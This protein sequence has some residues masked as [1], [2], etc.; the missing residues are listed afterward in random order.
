MWGLSYGIIEKR[1]KKL[2]RRMVA[3]PM[4][5]SYFLIGLIT[6]RVG[7]NFVE[8]GLLL[9]FSWLVFGITIQGNIPALIALFIAGNIAF[10]GIAVFISCHTSSTEV[11]NG[12]INAVVMPMMVLSGVFFSYHNFPD[13]SISFIQKLPLTMVADGIRSLI[14]EGAGIM[15]VSASFFILVAIGVVFFGAGLR[16]FKWY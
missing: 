9:L 6:V 1:S 14:I 7:M 11:G 10:A 8:S 4:K 13:W 3:T 12:F 2:L 5:K 16:I 15:D